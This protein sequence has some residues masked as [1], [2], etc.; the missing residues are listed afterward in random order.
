MTLI[1]AVA[2]PVADTGVDPELV[3]PGLLGFG[4][5][6]ALAL[7]TI[8][9][10][11]SFSRHLRRVNVNAEKLEDR[12]Q[13]TGAAAGSEAGSAAAAAE[14]G[15]S[16]DGVADGTADGAVPDGAAAGGGEAS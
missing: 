10:A 16:E 9:L 4:V 13:V 15:A 12:R 1:H 8:A 11:R 6:F 14:D 2:I 7:A 5:F 3:T